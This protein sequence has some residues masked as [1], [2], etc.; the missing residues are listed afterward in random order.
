MIGAVV[1][2]P[3]LAKQARIAEGCFSRDAARSKALPPNLPLRSAQG[4]EPSISFLEF[5]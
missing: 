5:T 2:A 1:L 3:S 4:E